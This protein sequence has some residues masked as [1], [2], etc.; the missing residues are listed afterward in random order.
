MSKSTLSQVL[1]A[2]EENAGPVTLSQIARDLDV[3]LL[4]SDQDGLEQITQA[5]TQA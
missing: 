1:A 3:V 5:L 4:R 2:F